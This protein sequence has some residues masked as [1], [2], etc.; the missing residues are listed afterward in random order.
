MRRGRTRVG[1]APKTQ[2]NYNCKYRTVALKEEEEVFC[3]VLDEG[4]LI[5]HEVTIKAGFRNRMDQGYYRVRLWDA[6][7]FS[8]SQL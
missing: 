5:L 3:S 1:P 6:A 4:K 7:K 8:L 2:K